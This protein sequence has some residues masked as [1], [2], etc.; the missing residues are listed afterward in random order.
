VY[1]I[2]GFWDGNIRAAFKEFHR[3]YPDRKQPKR[4]VSATVLSRLR[5]STDLCHH[6]TLAAADA[7]CRMKGTCFMLCRLIQRLA[8]VGADMNKATPRMYAAEANPATSS[9]RG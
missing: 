4:H 5:R 7:V 3:R 1:L 8:F 9:C 2:Y 6:Y